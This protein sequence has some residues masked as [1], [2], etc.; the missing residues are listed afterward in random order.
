MAPQQCQQ[1]VQARRGKTFV[2]VFVLNA[3][4]LDCRR[5]AG[6]SA[7]SG[8]CSLSEICPLQP[9][10]KARK[11]SDAMGIGHRGLIAT[12]RAEAAQAAWECRAFLCCSTAP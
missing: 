7:A 10:L 1:P 4:L 2:A 9:V 6:A 8:P 3:A 11:H 12:H 5:Q